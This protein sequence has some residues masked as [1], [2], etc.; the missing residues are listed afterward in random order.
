M[1]AQYITDRHDI[2]Y[3]KYDQVT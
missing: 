1:A 2:T 3:M